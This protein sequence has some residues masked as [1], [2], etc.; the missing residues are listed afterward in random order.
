[1]TPPF[2]IRG[3]LR[4]ESSPLQTASTE[5][6]I[7]K[8][9]LHATWPVYAQPEDRHTQKDGLYLTVSRKKTCLGAANDHIM[10]QAVLRSDVVVSL[11]SFELALV[12]KLAYPNP[13]ASQLGKKAPVV[14]PPQ[15]HSTLI[16]EQK[17]PT[18][19]I[20]QPGTHKMC[21]LTCM[22]PPN[23]AAMTVATARLIENTY[24]VYVSAIL[25]GGGSIA[26]CMPITV[27]PFPIA[28]S[29]DMMQ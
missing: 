9:E 10:M 1:M 20:I 25:D 21:E 2:F 7:L 17:R 19:V 8:H 5:I 14:Q 24:D 12:Q 27:S 26:V 16:S 11:K 23:Y 22:L 28:Y 4:R 15:P 18:D 13:G 3:L 6:V 29:M